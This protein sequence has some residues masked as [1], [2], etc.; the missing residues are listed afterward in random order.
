[1]PFKKLYFTY[2]GKV[3]LCCRDY[4]EDIVVGDIQQ[5]SLID[6][7]NGVQADQVRKKHLDK[8]KMDI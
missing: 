4:D 7:W 2:G 6:I 3:T 1:M 5:D 8:K